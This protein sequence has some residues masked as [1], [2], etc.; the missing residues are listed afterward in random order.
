MHKHGTWRQQK[1]LPNVCSNLIH[2]D[3]RESLKLS[4]NVL[5]NN[6]QISLI[7]PKYNKDN[8]TSDLKVALKV[9]SCTPKLYLS[10]NRDSFCIFN[11][12]EKQFTDVVPFREKVEFNV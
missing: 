1:L 11:T 2:G 8:A 9:A 5:H 6:I 4:N 10:Y 3:K 12:F 7:Q